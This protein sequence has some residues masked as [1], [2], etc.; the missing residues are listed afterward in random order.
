M[1][2]SKVVVGKKDVI[3][4]IISTIIAG[5]H[6]LL[7]GVPGVAKTLI[8]KAVASSLGLDFARIQFVPDLLPS[9]I[10]GTMVFRGGEFVF[11]KGPIFTE[12]LL[13]DEV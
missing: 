3:D 2:V 9:D 1:E 6:V 8:A 4:G 11:H 10:T 5:G 13:V 12:I 7:E